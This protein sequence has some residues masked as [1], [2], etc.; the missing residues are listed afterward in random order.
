MNTRPDPSAS[1]KPASISFN[2]S[3][4]RCSFAQEKNYVGKCFP[5]MDILDRKE[6]GTLQAVSLRIYWSA[7]P[8]VISIPKYTCFPKQTVE[9]FG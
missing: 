1:C 2:N 6:L 4:N 8:D 9:K 3:G 7:F 5:T